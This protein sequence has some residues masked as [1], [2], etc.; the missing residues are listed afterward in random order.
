M[1]G[2]A[3]EAIAFLMQN[4]SDGSVL[5]DVERHRGKKRRRSLDSNAYF[6]VLCDRLRQVL[7]I[8]M[9]SCKNH[10]IC[11][12]G[13]VEYIGDG[14]PLFYKTNAPPEYVA[15]LESVHMAPV[16]AAKGKKGT[17]WYYRVYRGSSTYNSEEMAALI[18]GTVD[19]CREQGIE[20]ATPDELM[21]MAALWEKRHG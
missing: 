8:S 17:V 14:E 12:Y 1:T 7:G 21:R 16:R 4:G 19:E 13:R 5:W 18:Q 10:L 6:H 20:T 9:A 3:R 15:E 2:N 11:S